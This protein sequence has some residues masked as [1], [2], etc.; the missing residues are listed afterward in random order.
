MTF[1]ITD[2]SQPFKTMFESTHGDRHE[3]PWK[4]LSRYLPSQ[5]CDHQLW[6]ERLAP[7]IGSSLGLTDYGL[8]A[9]YRNLLLI[10]SIVIP[11]LGPFPNKNGAKSTW[12]DC[13]ANN[14]GPLDVSVN[15]QQ[16]SK[17]AFRITVEPV[18]LHAG[19]Q[20]DI[21]N[22]LAPKSLLQ[23]LNH[24]QPDIDF[25]W[26]DHLDRTLILNTQQAR[27]YWS[28]MEHLPCKSQTVIGLDLHED[29]FTV[30]PYLS[31]LL[32]AAATG[33]NFLRVMFDN[34]RDLCSTSNLKLGLSKVEE[35]LSST[36]HKIQGEKTYLSFDCKSPAQS[37][38]KIYSAVDGLDIDNGFRI[39][40]KMW[41]R[42]YRCQMPAAKSREFLTVNFNWEVSP[43]DGNVAPK[44]Y[45]LVSDDYDKHISLAV[46]DLFQELGWEDHIH[47]HKAL[48]KVAYSAHDLEG[49]TDI[50]VW[51]A[52]AYST[53]SGPYVTVYTNPLARRV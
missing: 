42:I 45:F 47:R 22:E 13:M 28:L 49:R 11:S 30:K 51:L 53:G 39:V 19:D 50:Y 5:S 24:I 33:D 29:S 38:I 48:E 16:G 12:I 44:A 4:V 14:A 6:W 46:I 41:N 43:K 21:I 17:C 40:E 52:F 26:F 25:T 10:Y 31:P 34:L 23:N 15:Y 8:G 1:V 32:N 37:R 35:Y 2:P 20:S 3:E 9:Q 27:Q 18:G 36:T 7:V